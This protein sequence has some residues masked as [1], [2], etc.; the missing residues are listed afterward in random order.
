MSPVIAPPVASCTRRGAQPDAHPAPDSLAPPRHRAG[1]SG[2]AA[3]QVLRSLGHS[4]IELRSG[5]L[6]ALEPSGARFGATRLGFASPSQRSWMS[7]RTSNVEE[8]Q[9]A[10]IPFDD[11][12]SYRRP[13]GPFATLE[14][15][16]AEQ[17]PVTLPHDAL[18]DEERRAD[19]PSKGASA[20][21]PPGAYTYVK[22]FDVPTE[23]AEKLIFLELQGAYRHAMI[24]VNEEFVGNRADG[25]ARFVLD[26]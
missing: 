21:Y 23:W 25:Y 3:F 12:W 9:M 8:V 15:A 11:D 16:T 24:F 19:V 14:G 13:L 5:A 26:L 20:Y 10:R 4:P 2:P 17:T 7:D 22:S 1:A 18:R 6:S